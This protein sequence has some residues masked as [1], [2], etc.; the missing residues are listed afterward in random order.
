MYKVPHLRPTLN[1]WP[2]NLD[3]HDYL[4]IPY[5]TFLYS[6]DNMEDFDKVEAQESLIKEQDQTLKFA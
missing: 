3:E 1:Y 5:V 4:Y 2:N 6:T